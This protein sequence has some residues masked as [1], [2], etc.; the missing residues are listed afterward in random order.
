MVKIIMRLTIAIATLVAAMCFD[1]P[2]S[3]A[4]GD[5][6]W[7]KMINQGD[8]QVYFDCEYRTFEA[9]SSSM[10]RGFCNLNPWPGPST[11]NPVAQP[12]H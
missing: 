6:P 7:C 2:A 12:K 11:P 5:A 8:D 4:F 9:C 1:V 3:R 10:D